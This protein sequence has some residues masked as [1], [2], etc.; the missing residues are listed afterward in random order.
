MRPSDLRGLIDDLAAVR[1]FTDGR[2][3][4][5]EVAIAGAQIVLRSR[6]KCG[7]GAKSSVS[8]STRPAAAAPGTF[9]VLGLV[10]REGSAVEVGTIQR[11][12][13]A[14]S[15]SV[16]HLHESEAARTARVAIADQ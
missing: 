10:D 3:R 16:R 8:E 2:C 5:A 7:S 4:T 9:A 11:L 1:K 15:I 6:F 12:H 14:R 13:C